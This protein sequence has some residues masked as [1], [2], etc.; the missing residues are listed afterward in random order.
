LTGEKNAKDVKI[1]PSNY[2]TSETFVKALGLNLIEGRDFTKMDMVEADPN[3]DRKRGDAV[4]ITKELG[5]RLFPDA[6]SYVGKPVYWGGGDNTDVSTVVGVVE[7]LQTIS[8]Q[9]S[10]F[11]LSG[12]YSVI[13]PTRGSIPTSLFAVRTESGERDRLMKEVETLLRQSYNGSAV[14]KTKSFESIRNSRYRNDKGLALL[15]S[16]LSIV[17]LLVTVSGVV[18]MTS[19]WVSQRKKTIGVRRALGAKQIDII[20]YFLTENVLITIVGVGLGAL[21]ALGLNQL[22]STKFSIDKLPLHYL[23][24]ACVLFFV[25]GLIAAF[26]PARRA[27]KISPAIAT[28]GL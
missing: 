14:I 27:A 19:M 12:E 1:S 18:G 15:L 13:S 10:R 4:I 3:K 8:A 7:R 28:R 24:Y 22:I 25:L 26:S 9:S 11:G 17:L 21:L 5:K 23:A 16:A 20:R 6:T 2:S